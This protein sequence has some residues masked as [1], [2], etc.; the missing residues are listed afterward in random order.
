VYFFNRALMK[1]VYEYADKWEVS[2]AEAVISLISK[3]LVAE[4]LLPDSKTCEHKRIYEMSRGRVCCL[5][6]G[7]EWKN[8]A[9]YEEEREL[10]EIMRKGRKL[11]TGKGG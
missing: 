2:V 9:K 11:S 7:E 3:A 6:C 4:K 10:M 5:T 1:A 8:P